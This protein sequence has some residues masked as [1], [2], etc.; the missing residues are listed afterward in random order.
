MGSLCCDSA[1]EAKTLIPSL[2]HKKTDEE[3]Q[4]LLN[5]VCQSSP[6]LFWLSGV[7]GGGGEASVDCL[8]GN[9]SYEERERGWEIRALK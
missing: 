9:G 8:V 1:E 4:D 2:E 6:L 5:E 7:E 3:L